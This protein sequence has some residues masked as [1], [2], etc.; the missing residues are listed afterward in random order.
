MS[1]DFLTTEEMSKR[2]GITRRRI[3]ELCKKGR[4]EGAVLKGKMWLL[5]EDAT[6]PTDPRRNCCQN[7]KIEKGSK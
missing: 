2:W 1:M 7:T 3:A 5:P 6:K 4:I